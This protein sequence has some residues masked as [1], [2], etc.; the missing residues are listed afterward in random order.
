MPD[1]HPVYIGAVQPAPNS[2]FLAIAPEDLAAAYADIINKG[3]ESEFYGMF[4]AA[5]DE[6]RE[7]IAVDRKDRLDEFNETAS[8]TGSLTF[9]SAPGEFAPFALA[10]VESGAIVAVNINETDTVK[11]TNADAVIKLE[12]NA[13]VKALAG[14]DQ[15][16]TGFTTTF[17]DQVFF[18]VP[19]QGSSEK[20][21]LLGYASDILD[22]KV[23]K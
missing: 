2:Q 21:R 15:S 8:N 4:E 6:L 18:Y 10:T 5:G 9:A 1:L 17:T 14:A 22:A 20:I 16:A 13:T 19:T 3:E 7:R 11:P 23:I 12:N